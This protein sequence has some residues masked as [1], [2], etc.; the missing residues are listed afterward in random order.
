MKKILKLLFTLSA[1]LILS[2]PVFAANKAAVVPVNVSARPAFNGDYAPDPSKSYVVELIPNATMKL[3]KANQLGLKLFIPKTFFTAVGDNVRIEPECFCFSKAKKELEIVG[4]L[5]AKYMYVAEMTKEGVKLAV[6]DTAA[7]KV[8]Y[9]ANLKENGEY[10]IASID[11][12]PLNNK[13]YL[14]SSGKYGKINTKKAFV[15]QPTIT[16]TIDTAAAAKGTIY[17]D[18]LNIYASKT[19]KISFSKK[20]YT[21]L[22]IYNLANVNKRTNLIVDLK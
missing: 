13:A 3:K 11:K 5:E 16:V 18:Q 2:C 12:L 15:L 6:V 7:G 17:L 20:I 1:V 19:L 21:G 9:S 14:Y 22:Y 4:D 8:Q 10:Y